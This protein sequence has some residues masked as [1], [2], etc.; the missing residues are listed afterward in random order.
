MI[1]SV[2]LG[3]GVGILSDADADADALRLPIDYEPC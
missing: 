2:A 1:D 3:G